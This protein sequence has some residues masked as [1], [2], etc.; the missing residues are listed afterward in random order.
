M[1]YLVSFI[2]GVWSGGGYEISAQSPSKAAVSGLQKY[3]KEWEDGIK[4]K[5]DFVIVALLCILKKRMGNY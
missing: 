3:G 2:G 4:Q 5:I 1:D